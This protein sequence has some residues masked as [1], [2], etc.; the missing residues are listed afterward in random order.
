MRWL[1]L[2]LLLVTA[3]GASIADVDAQPST[4]PEA[5]EAWRFRVFLDD[6]EIGYHHFY[7]AENGET[8][9]LRS[10]ADFEYHLLFVKVYDY[11]HENLETWAGNCLQSVQSR[12]DANGTP[13]AV[14]GRRDPEG[15]RVDATDV[16]DTL[17]ECVMSFAYWNPAF[18]EQERLLNT[19]NG[20]F[21]QVDVSEPVSEPVLVRGEQRPAY[22]YR[23]EAGDL[24]LDLWYSAD[25]EW[26]ALES[27]VRGGRILRYELM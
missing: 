10:V 8:R 16:E 26:L 9:Q 19:Q 1:T 22:R 27:E 4:E 25:K 12:T 17:P 21:L 3:L 13:Y 24:N 20:E 23:V 14:N 15:F 2:L 11:E 5:G 6:R 7:L 18:L